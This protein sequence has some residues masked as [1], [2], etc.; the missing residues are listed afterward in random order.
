MLVLVLVCMCVLV[1]DVFLVLC[2]C[3]F[4]CLAAL[5]QFKASVDPSNAVLKDWSNRLPHCTWV[6]VTCDS[7][8]NIIR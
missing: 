6:Y 1:H 4:E 5:L 3:C 2:A 7:N 8:K